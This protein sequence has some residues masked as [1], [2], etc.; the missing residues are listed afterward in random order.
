LR[1]VLT[2]YK[3]FI[4]SNLLTELKNEKV[5]LI[6]AEDYPLR[7]RITGSDAVIHLG[8]ISGA[9]PSI[10][11]YS[12]FDY[13]VKKTVELLEAASLAKVKKFIFVSTCTVT[14][15][16]RNIY[17][18]SKQQAEQWCVFYR[19][20]IPD[21]PILRLYNVYGE[22]D[23]KSV[24]YKYVNAVK[25]S[26]PITIHGDGRQKRDFIDVKDVVRGIRKALY[27]KE[28]LD[29]PIGIGTGKET[30]IHD[31]A[32]LIF[33]LSGRK[34]PVRY[35]PIPYPQLESAKC[36]EP[37]FLENPLTIEEGLRLMMKQPPTALR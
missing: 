9:N 7:E 31:L 11:F 19:A 15:G 3:G 33:R 24:V 20:R 13:N 14:H 23:S 25:D 18:V 28:T 8:A 36:P 16:V 27:S 2:G 5:V 10:P 1:I 6:E 29:Q 17:D 21:I 37:L 35:E 30:S 32:D 12:Y 4:A 22:G 34:V 26:R